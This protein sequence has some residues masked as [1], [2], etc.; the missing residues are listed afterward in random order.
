MHVLFLADGL[1]PFVVGGMQKHSTMLIKHL[2]PLVDQ[3]TVCTC[4]PTNA[5]PPP[6]EDMLAELVTTK[7]NV[8]VLACTFK[9]TGKLPGHYLRASRRLSRTYLNLAGDLSQYDCIYA[10]GL[11]GDAFLKKHPRVMVNLHGLNMFQPSFSWKE[12]VEKCVMRP[13]FAKQIR[14]AWKVV[15]LGG[16]LTDILQANGAR[17]ERIVVLPNGVDDCWLDTPKAARKT[18]ETRFLMVGR[19]DPAKGYEVLRD[20]LTLIHEPVEIH[21]VGDWPEFESTHHNLTYHGVLRDKEQMMDVMDS[22]DALLLPS[23]SEGM[24][25]VV[26]EAKA[27]GLQVIGTDVGAMKELETELM[28]PGDEK[29]LALRM[30]SMNRTSDISGLPDKFRWVEIAKNTL[31]QLA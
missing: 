23:L 20:A 25:T 6:R 26:L 17:K 5:P 13:L 7:F 27:R 4:G 18:K 22:C 28:L 31:E 19:N 11:T 2:S 30:S 9:D 24:P 1:F 8:E 10:Q 16:K 3:I 21:F 29:E 14:L 15:S 12:S